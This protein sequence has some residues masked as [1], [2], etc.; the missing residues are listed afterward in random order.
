MKIDT[1][2]FNT[3]HVN[4]NLGSFSLPYVLQRNFNTSHVNVNLQVAHIK[5][6][7]VR[8]SIHLMLMLI[9]KGYW[10]RFYKSSISIHLM[11]MLIYGVVL[12]DICLWTISIHLM[13]ML[14]IWHFVVQRSL[15]DFNTSHVNVNLKSIKKRRYII[16]NFN[17]SHVNVNH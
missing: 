14:I 1:F 16:I 13:L 11:L 10:R 17:T 12:Q 5:R 8:I 6:V 9:K 7:L 2:H 15:G 4:V 3:S